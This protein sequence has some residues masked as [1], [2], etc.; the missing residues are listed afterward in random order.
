M[1]AIARELDFGKLQKL[2]DQVDAVIEGFG[3]AE[4]GANLQSPAI[5]GCVCT[6][7]L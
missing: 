2:R 3:D 7:R 6:A 5:Q 1:A 4:L